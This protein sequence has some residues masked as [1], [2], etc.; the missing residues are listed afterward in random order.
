MIHYPVDKHLLK[1]NSKTIGTSSLDVIVDL[2]CWVWVGIYQ[3]K[4]IFN[5]EHVFMYW[6]NSLTL[7]VVNEL[8]ECVWPFC[9]V[10][11]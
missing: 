5:F 2:F 8:R 4:I 11:S 10:G 9:G 6:V 3:Q 7:A 1:A